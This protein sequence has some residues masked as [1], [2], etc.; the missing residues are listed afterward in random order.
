M[1]LRSGRETDG[2]RELSLAEGVKMN[3]P[4]VT[5]NGALRQDGWETELVW[6]RPWTLE[7]IHK[8]S[9]SWSLGADAGLLLF[10]QDFSQQ[11]LS[12][13]HEIEKQ[14]DSLIQRT[15]A[16]DSRLHNVFNDFLMLSNI[17][18]I[19]NRVYDEEVED[20]TKPESGGKPV[21]PEKTRE[22]KEAELIPKI[23][24]AVHHGL[25]VLDSAFEQLD[26][27]AGNSDSEDEETNERV[28][29]LLEPKDLYIDRPLPY[30]IG[31]QQFMEEEDVGLGDLSS[32]ESVDSEHGSVI[33]SE[34][35]KEESGVDSAEGSEDEEQK[36]SKSV[37]KQ[38]QISD[39]DEDDDSDLFQESGKEEEEDDLTLTKKMGQT[40]FAEELA[41]RI[42]GE[43][44]E[45][46]HE[47]SASLTSGVSAR[48]NRVKTK[49]EIQNAKHQED[50]ENLFTSE[51]ADEEDDFSP[52]RSKS[53]LFSGGKGLFD[54]E[55]DLFAEAP[56]EELN[57][58]K[59]VKPAVFDE[60]VAR[61]SGKKVP[62]GAVSIYPGGDLFAP[63]VISETAHSKKAKREPVN[64]GGL[65]DDEEDDLFGSN[66][67]TSGA[68]KTESKL[69]TSLFD[70]SEDSGLF[71]AS[72]TPKAVKGKSGA[73]QNA[74]LHSEVVESSPPLV[75]K[76][77][78]SS[79]LFSDDD[80]SQ[81]LFSSN[82]D[83]KRHQSKQSLVQNT[84][85]QIPV[86]FFDDEG[87]LFSS[88]PSK[89]V[90]ATKK[91]QQPHEPK[92]AA[93]GSK[94]A[95]LFDSDD[96]DEWQSLGQ[97]N[98]SASQ[99]VG[100]KKQ[101]EPKAAAT[102]RAPKKISLFDYP[103][104]DDLFGV[105]QKESQKKSHK[106]SLLF[107]DDDEGDLFASKPA[108]NKPPP[109]QKPSPLQSSSLFGEIESNRSVTE[110]DGKR[111]VEQGAGGKPVSVG[112]T[113][114]F[115]GSDIL[116]QSDTKLVSEAVVAQEC[117]DL[118]KPSA[119]LLGE[120]HSNLNSVV[121][122]FDED[123][124]ENL[125]DV[126]NQSKLLKNE[127]LPEG[128]VS[129]RVFQDE[130][131]LFSQQQQKDN[132]PDVDLF[133][134]ALK[135]EVKTL[136]KK[137]PIS[138]PP[139]EKARP[140]ELPSSD[141][142]DGT[143][144]LFSTSK[145]RSAKVPSTKDSIFG[146]SVDEDLFRTVPKKPSV[147]QTKPKFR[148]TGMSWG[149]STK[150]S[151]HPQEACGEV[152]EKQR[153]GDKERLTT[154]T[155]PIKTK[156]PSSRIGKLQANL[157]I[158]PASLLPGAAPKKAVVPSGSTTPP[159]SPDSSLRAA[160][161]SASGS[162]AGEGITASLEQPVQVDVLPSVNKSRA[163]VGQK[164]R[165][166]TRVARRLA[167]QQSSERE[168]L[169]QRTE[170]DGVLLEASGIAD[171]SPT[172]TV[173]KPHLAKTPTSQQPSSDASPPTATSTKLP[174]RSSR[175]LFDSGDLFKPNVTQEST[176]AVRTL[177]GLLPKEDPVQSIFAPSEDD[178]FQ[179]SKR[180]VKKPKPV[181]FLQEEDD[182][183]FGTPKLGKTKHTAQENSKTP[184]IFEDDLFS[185]ESITLTKK[186][187]EGSASIDLFSDHVDIFA[188]LKV[189]PKEKK[190]RKK[191]ETKS[192]FD[193]DM[194]DI[195]ASA[196]PSSNSKK[197][198][199][200][201]ASSK[202]AAVPVSTADSKTVDI[203]D[204]PLNAFGP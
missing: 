168:D 23:Q 94:S 55:G 68:D 98:I 62:V 173:Q 11:M 116:E 126:H 75:E 95:A 26:I 144:D 113:H 60:P 170:V 42:Q 44:T 181:A 99:S 159:S 63:N 130:E 27:K 77:Q 158:N 199:K 22:Q 20:A 6:E 176:P 32:E 141:L 10:L 153:P 33:E 47:Q 88:A 138:P 37:Q 84:S 120:L 175:D 134:D 86:S 114:L 34:E 188:D 128:G 182:D 145:P 4:S 121:S 174:V 25:S 79:G 50:E 93:T 122:L 133:A 197:Q 118:A 165:P 41:A 31:S 140:P 17:Q 46:Q 195:F 83:T 65:F 156:G 185:T 125:E 183:L 142:F 74:Q 72:V 124:D 139:T 8:A 18:F 148:G 81:D 73:Q 162:V 147:P 143:D 53:G 154:S 64:T 180:T 200:P 29:H 127:K 9:G 198:S 13:T 90:S 107:E 19:E 157:A 24:E 119:G 105:T 131:L 178:L 191:V 21:E 132:D 85:S 100:E 184:D 186:S 66:V 202:Q 87:D 38:Q 203:F 172:V 97:Q 82:K 48:K 160:T 167:A 36:L 39:E 89:D 40:S 106:V 43:S 136:G 14:L 76:S 92:T 201:K 7:E 135:S 190:S 155:G 1:R 91:S 108:T 169:E 96:K 28:E 51:I 35:E 49:T 177:E 69:A 104:E 45:K 179:S 54:D 16:T 123:E 151:E 189:T 5:D 187:N 196:T 117:D 115:A 80:D 150:T 111:Q 2:S 52:F 71:E 56:K 110:F 129:T 152:L 67:K 193:D 30:I 61:K 137:P 163:R 161:P 102:S 101:E 171:I 3:G 194:D 78:T 57:K 12:R 109:S 70:E 15:K 58:G 149:A 164:R 59:E 192:I 103:E 146:D 112:T 204:D 166:P